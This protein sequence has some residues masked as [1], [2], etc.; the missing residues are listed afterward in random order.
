[1][2]MRPDIYGFKLESVRG[3][4]G[5]DNQETLKKISNLYQKMIFDAFGDE[6][7]TLAKFREQ[8]NAI[9]WRAIM[10]EAPFPDLDSENSIHVYAAKSIVDSTEPKSVGDSLDW[11]MQAFRD[12]RMDGEGKLDPEIVNLLRVFESGRPFFGRKIESDWNYY[13][14]LTAKE[15]KQLAPAIDALSES[16]SANYMDGFHLAL[17]DWLDGI[18][19]QNL[20]LWFWVY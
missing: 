7:D 8:G 1:M 16:Q 3:L 17:A 5:S 10:E 12:L 6:P 20:D 9:I 15:V 2:S 14:Y 19:S 4:F 18:L 11:H 13:G